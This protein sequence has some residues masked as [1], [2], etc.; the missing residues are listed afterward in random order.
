M[1]LKDSDVN[2][3]RRLLGYVRCEIAQSPE[4]FKET[5]REIAPYCDELT[6]A[7]QVM[8]VEHYHKAEA[9][10]RYVRAAVKALEKLLRDAE[11]EIIPGQCDYPGCTLP[12]GGFH[13]HDCKVTN[14]NQAIGVLVT[15]ASDGPST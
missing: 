8:L 6:S 15:G 13:V 4:E 1:K 10:P 14:S 7:A 12:P 2:H 3:L 5:L 9:V 11:G